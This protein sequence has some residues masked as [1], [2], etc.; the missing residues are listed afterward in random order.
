[1]KDTTNQ[2]QGFLDLAETDGHGLGFT[3]AIK[4]KIYVF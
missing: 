2:N 4:A 3:V 1:M